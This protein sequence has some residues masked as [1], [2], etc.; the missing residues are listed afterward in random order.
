MADSAF[1][2]QYRQEF[3]KGFEQ[4]ESLV[5]KTVTTEVEIKGNQA[6]FLVA[7]SGGAQAKTRGVNGLIPARAD[8][9][10]QVPATLQEWHDLSRATS[11]N[12][13]ASQGDR[14]AIMQMTTR[15]VLNR[16]IDN[17][18]ITTLDS[19]VTQ[20]AG[21]A[22]TGS[23]ALVLRAK[24]ILGNNAVPLGSNIFSLISPAFEAYLMQTKEFASAEYINKKNPFE[25]PPDFDDQ[26]TTFMWN[27]I[28]FV[29]HP[30][31]TGVGTA[32]EFC[33]LYHRSA[34]GH[35]INS[36]DLQSLVGYFEEQD[37][38]WA[39]TSAFMGT[40]ALQTQGIVQIIHDGSAF[41]AT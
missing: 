21:P 13:F 6:M 16:K 36:A 1:Q 2:I 20:H 40:A 33:Y 26:P 22:S 17:D 11:F 41:A 8:S 39:R 9:L 24:T 18:I 15:G 23:L 5:R 31:L 30:N 35:A 19:A 29:V 3:I 38:S 37:Y 7:S 27:G 28:G 34:V 32:A 10:T 14:N 4:H 25:N 12:I